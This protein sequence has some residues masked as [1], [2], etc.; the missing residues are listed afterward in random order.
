MRLLYHLAM[1]ALQAGMRGAALL[2][3]KIRAGVQGRARWREAY[4]ARFDPAGKVMWMHVASLGEFEQ[5]RPVIEAFRRRYP[6]W[7][8]ALTFFSPSG[9]ELRK[10]YP[11][12][13]FV[14]YLP[15]DTP[16]NARDFVAWLRPEL[17]IFVKYEFWANY[18][19]EMRRRDI[20]LLLTASLFRPQQPFFQWYG[21][22]WRDMLHCYTHIFTQTVASNAL[23]QQAGYA[24]VSVAGDPRVDR[25]L[26]ISAAAAANEIVEAFTRGAI[27]LVVGSSWPPDEDALITALRHP[28]LQHIKVV[29]A[30]HTPQ[31]DYVASLR[32]K[33]PAPALLYSEAGTL[34]EGDLAAARWLIID[35][36][37][38]LNTLYRYGHIAYIGGGFGVAIHNTLEPAAFGLPVVF[39]PKYHKFEEA[40]QLIALGG[41]VAVSDAAAL[42]AVLLQWMDA[43]TRK[44]ASA[45]V[46]QYMQN[47]R[48]GTSAILSWISTFLLKKT[49]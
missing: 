11:L 16:S 46:V 28:A 31:R 12:A 25:V 14:G 20:P 29:C 5:G 1:Y 35:N 42:E 23:L 3:A 38:M 48:G 17:V 9:Y 21:G 10:N 43:E 4:A 30:P 33:I 39:G 24:R 13:D 18:L 6:D 44:S 37:G 40:I 27:T 7:K 49:I 45:A 41:A 22:F 34:S 32:K 26:D 19:H 8:I 15:I 2:N 36:V 47:S